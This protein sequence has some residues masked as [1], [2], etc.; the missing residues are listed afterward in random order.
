MF[1]QKYIITVESESPPRI[2]LGDKIYG[3]EV[4]SLEVEQFPDLVDLAWLTKRFPLSRQTIAAK[5]EILNLGGPR[6]KLYDP[7]V[8]IPFLKTDFKSRRGRPRKN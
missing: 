6:K 2:C 5:L 4:V 3:A 1:K 7:N 8:V